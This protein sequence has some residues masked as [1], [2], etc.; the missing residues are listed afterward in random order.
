[1]P[2]CHP[3]VIVHRSPLRARKYA[4]FVLFFIITLPR[5]DRSAKK[6]SLEMY[7]VSLVW[8]GAIVESVLIEPIVSHYL[9]IFF[10]LRRMGNN[11]ASHT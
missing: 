6:R 3:D 11:K 7:L 5:V 1:M 9:F 4:F 10:I 8:G 2:F